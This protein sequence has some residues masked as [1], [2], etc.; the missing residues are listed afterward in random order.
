MA[1]PNTTS[2]TYNWNPAT[3]EIGV[4]AFD[5]IG[6]RPT[7]LTRHHWASFRRSMNFALQGFG[8]CGV[9]LWEVQLGTIQLVAGQATYTAGT[10]VSNISPNIVSMLDVYFTT[11]NG[12]G[13]GINTDRILISL[14]RSQYAALPNKA[15]Q[16][17]PS[18]F[19]F[20]RL[21]SVPQITFYQVPQA[22]YPVNEVNYYFLSRIQDATAAVG[23]IADVPYRF[24]DAL[25][26][27]MAKRLAR[28][29]APAMYEAAK[30]EAKES[31]DLAVT[32][33]QE[34]APIE[35][36]PDVSGYFRM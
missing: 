16:G 15:V 7:A 22:S 30:V 1:T 31:W 34:T 6:I 26:D 25:A 10:G 9:N 12:G 13:S 29:F 33:D 8:N 2:G 32:N 23:Q 11:I 17:Y 20:Q 21:E 4:E 35:I 19:W 28:K 27:E 36:M 5:R 18:Q 3:A 24:L 14:S